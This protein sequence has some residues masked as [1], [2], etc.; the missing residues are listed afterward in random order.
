MRRTFFTLRAKHVKWLKRE[1]SLMPDMSFQHTSSDSN[2]QEKMNFCKQNNNG[3]KHA[4]NYSLTLMMV[5]AP[6]RN[7][8]KYFEYI[9]YM[10]CIRYSHHNLLLLIDQ[11]QNFSLGSR[12][13]NQSFRMNGKIQVN[14]HTRST[15]TASQA[16]HEFD[17]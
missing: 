14:Q 9:K 8:R 13:L 3:S 5:C 7:M 6:F 11:S 1:T 17:K 16:L 10:R 4:N 12:I 15:Y 2:Y